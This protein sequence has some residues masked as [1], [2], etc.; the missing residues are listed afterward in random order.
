[1]VAVEHVVLAATKHRNVLGFAEL[2]DGV[3]SS[4]DGGGN[5][6]PIEGA[7]EAE[8]LDHVAQHWSA[9]QG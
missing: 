6:H 2:D 1:M 7:A 3:V 4:L 8:P 9:S 5:H